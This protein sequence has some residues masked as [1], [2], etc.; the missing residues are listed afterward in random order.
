M[1]NPRHAPGLDKAIE[2]IYHYPLLES[3][4][5]LLAR[6]IREHIDDESLAKLAVDLRSE[7]QL[8]SVSEN[9]DDLAPKIICSLGMR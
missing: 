4:R 3:A 6:R 5:D 7:N 2:D 8:C 1:N 9:P